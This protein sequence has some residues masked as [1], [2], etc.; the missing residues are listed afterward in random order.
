MS[1]IRELEPIDATSKYAI[2]IRYGLMVGFV[3]MFLTTINFL[4]ILDISYMAFLVGGFLMFAVP[5]AFYAIAATRQRKMLD[6]FLSM[7]EAFQVIFIVILIS[8]TINTIYGLI[9]NNFIDPDFIIRMKASMI[10]FFENLKMPEEKI[11]EVIAKVEESTAGASKPT[12]IIY[13]FAQ[14]IIFQSIFGFIV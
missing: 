9:Y 12:K 14:G 11:D 6:G 2:A 8:M 1:E 10:S 5:I 13:S 4:Y 7:K 3:S